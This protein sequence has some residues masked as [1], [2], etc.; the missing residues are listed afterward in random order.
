MNFGL[1]LCCKDIMQGDGI[2]VV[3]FYGWVP[4]VGDGDDLC[5]ASV[6]CYGKLVS[7]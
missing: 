4:L 6:G 7:W 3:G 1:I 5:T 2:V